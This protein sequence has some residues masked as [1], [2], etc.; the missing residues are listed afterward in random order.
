MLALRGGVVR[1]ALTAGAAR[2]YSLPRIALSKPLS[3]WT[4]PIAARKLRF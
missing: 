4:R 1:P 3:G 2:R